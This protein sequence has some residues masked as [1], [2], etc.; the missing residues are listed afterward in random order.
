[1]TGGNSSLV[2]YLWMFAAILMVGTSALLLTFFGNG[3]DFGEPVEFLAYSCSGGGF[4]NVVT[5]FALVNRWTRKRS[6]VNWSRQLQGHCRRVGFGRDDPLFFCSHRPSLLGRVALAPDCHS[7]H[8]H[9]SCFGDRAHGWTGRR[10]HADSSS[11]RCRIRVF[12]DCF[13]N[14]RGFGGGSDPS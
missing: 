4:I 7:V 3:D 5:G 9:G 6:L 2:I 14:Y 12:P 10:T 8:Y 11:H 1:M 13:Q